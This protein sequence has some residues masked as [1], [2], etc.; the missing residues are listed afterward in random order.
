MCCV[1]D[2][3]EKPLTCETT[4]KLLPFK[5]ISLQKPKD[6]FFFFYKP[7]FKEHII[8]TGIPGIHSA[9]NPWLAAVHCPY[10]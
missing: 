6:Y 7:M 3:G 1:N 4:F 10:V 2:S 8:P 5:T 9:L